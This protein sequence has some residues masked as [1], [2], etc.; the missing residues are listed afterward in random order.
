M[1]AVSDCSQDVNPIALSM[2]THRSRPSKS[3]SHDPLATHATSTAPPPNP[4]FVFPMR[5]AS[6]YAQ[7]PRS[8][9]GPETM[10][11]SFRGA[12][13]NHPALPDFSFNP[14]ANGFLSP[15][16]N[17]F[18]S[19]PETPATPH[20]T[21]TSPPSPRPMS[22]NRPG[23][24]HRRGGS[25]FVGGSIRGGDSITVLGMS[26]TKSESGFEVPADL[27]LPIGPP[28]RKGHA[29]RR[30]AAISS[31]DISKIMLPTKPTDHGHSAPN[32]PTNFDRRDQMASLNTAPPVPIRI[33]EVKTPEPP[34]LAPTV[35]PSPINEGFLVPSALGT[36]RSRVGFSETIEVIPRPLSV[37]STDTS[38]TVTV[39]AGHSL[40]GS[41]SSV[42]SVLPSPNEQRPT[43]ATSPQRSSL[44]TP[45]R[46]KLE[47]RPST[48]GAILDQMTNQSRTTFDT[49][50]A[51]RRNSIPTLLDV[52]TS[53]EEDS[54]AFSNAKSPKRWSFFSL[55][56]HKANVPSP[57]STELPYQ[58]SAGEEE[59][60]TQALEEPEPCLEEAPKKKKGKK[61]KKKKSKAKGS[62]GVPILG[63]KSK[64]QVR[65]CRSGS[66][67][68]VTPTQ[69]PQQVSS[70]SLEDCI[71]P[72][73]NQVMDP[74]DLSAPAASNIPTIELP[75][76]TPTEKRP[77]DDASASMIDLDAAL[78]PFN[79]PLSPNPEWEAAQRAAGNVKRK[80]HSAQG[81]K[82]FSG[83]GMHYHRRAESAPEMVPF[84]RSGFG[85]HRFG[86]NSTM[87]DVFEEDEEDEDA[88]ESDSS[89]SRSADITP[90]E[91]TPIQHA[92]SVASMATIADENVP[93]TPSGLRNSGMLSLPS[94]DMPVSTMKTENSS[95]S[96]KTELSSEGIIYA[97][98]RNPGFSNDSP[99]AS[100][101]PS[102]R[103]LIVGKE[104]VHVNISPLQLPS[105]TQTPVSP[106]ANS[107]GSF[108]SPMSPVSYDTHCLSTAP[109]SLNDENTFQSLL[110]GE[111]GPEVRI[112][113][114]I[115]SLTSTNSAGTRESAFQHPPNRTTPQLREER[116]VS[117]SSAFGRRRSSLASLS[118][119][120]NSS[121]GERSKLSMEIPVDE[122]EDRKTKPSRAKRISRLVQF[123]KPKESLS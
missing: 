84:E 12:S 42:V 112:S 6:S 10:G 18:L 118:R 121:Y 46:P 82:G 52:P 26:A 30:S 45:A 98:P 73:S 29:H 21:S 122:L 106:Y 27:K 53:S 89:S 79:T 4:H 78:G 37:M 15:D 8:A 17:S 62:W 108:P 48:A 41:I 31:H 101:N 80:L 57:S 88:I 65:K 24:G 67:R 107:S 68:S 75:E 86:S 59:L 51:K 70:A 5:P 38:S 54:I 100:A 94:A 99:C 60:P 114:D 34:I 56:A 43:T 9:M 71:V 66:L 63:R 77:E 92:S 111:P 110:R 50:T 19:P 72:D 61:S 97:P 35:P 33:L 13:K 23:H 119:L 39:R 120:I 95:C 14:G 96:L 81:M 49:S 76:D 123:W 28:K 93:S 87:A 22:A 74:E 1:A 40:S 69:M 11:S 20:T 32:S 117:V 55:D 102:P 90:T 116:P 25:E 16:K 113:V 85:V 58:D 109:S 103:R 115:P 47:S 2:P 104:L 105:A 91:R 44:E 3:Q 36:P 83:P 7:R 64:P